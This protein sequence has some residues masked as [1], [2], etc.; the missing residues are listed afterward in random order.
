[1]PP[2]TR[3]SLK[4]CKTFL[5]AI[6]LTTVSLMRL[7]QKSLKNRQKN[8]SKPMPNAKLSIS[9]TNNAKMVLMKY[10]RKLTKSLIQPKPNSSPPSERKRPHLNSSPRQIQYRKRRR[11]QQLKHKDQVLARSGHRA[12]ASVIFWRPLLSSRVPRQTNR[13]IVCQSCLGLKGLNPS[14]KPNSKFQRK[15]QIKAANLSSERTLSK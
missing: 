4:S 6:N 3:S 12:A 5:S 2:K 10:C 14:K 7:R 9:R 11:P 13:A 1:M 15:R 8:K